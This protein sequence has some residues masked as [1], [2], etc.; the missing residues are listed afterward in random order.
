LFSID[1]GNSQGA[2]KRALEITEQPGPYIEAT[3]GKKL[4]LTVKVKGEA[5]LRYK[6]YKDTRELMYATT[7]ILEIPSANQLDNG[8]YCCAVANDHGSILS[9]IY[10]VKVIQRPKNR[11]WFLKFKVFSLLL[12][13][14]YYSALMYNASTQSLLP[15]WQEYRLC[16]FCVAGVLLTTLSLWKGRGI[17][18]T[19][20]CCEH[21]NNEMCLLLWLILYAFAEFSVLHYFLVTLF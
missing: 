12:I 10:Q 16:L 11:G 5:P 15:I 1:A 9:E 20:F 7:N 13:Y 18:C 21:I 17:Q 19:D 4:Q 8:Q 2:Q 6:W 14:C 3:A